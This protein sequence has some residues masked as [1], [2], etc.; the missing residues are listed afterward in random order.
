[1][2]KILNTCKKKETFLKKIY[3]QKRFFKKYDYF[4][5]ESNKCDL[6]HQ[7]FQFFIVDSRIQRM[8]IA[9]SAVVLISNV[10]NIRSARLIILQNDTV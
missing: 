4:I 5:P 9:L 3:R 8:A 7:L 1:M 2:R 10:I 6:I